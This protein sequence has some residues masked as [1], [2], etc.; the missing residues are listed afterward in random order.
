VPNSTPDDAQN[1]KKV[2]GAPQIC[3]RFCFTQHGIPGEHARDARFK[4]DN[5]VGYKIVQ[6]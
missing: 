6:L 5:N 1:S 2:C 3:F 4:L